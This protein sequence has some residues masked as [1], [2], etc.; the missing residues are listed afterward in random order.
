MVGTGGYISAAGM[1]TVAG[2][3]LPLGRS[4][5]ELAVSGEKLDEEV[6]GGYALLLLLLPPPQPASV[7]VEAQACWGVGGACEFCW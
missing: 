2:V 7:G 1:T 4:T 3:L 6:G 5:Y